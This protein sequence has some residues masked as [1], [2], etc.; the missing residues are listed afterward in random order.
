MPPTW[1]TL[2]KCCSPLPLPYATTESF[3]KTDLHIP[4]FSQAAGLSLYIRI[5]ESVKLPSRQGC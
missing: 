1:Q 4:L 5:S 3:L 2:Y